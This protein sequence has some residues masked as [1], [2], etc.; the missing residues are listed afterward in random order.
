MLRAALNAT[1]QLLTILTRAT[2]PIA[3]RI[4]SAAA[5]PAAQPPDRNLYRP[6][7][8]RDGRPAPGRGAEAEA[9]R[10]LRQRRRAGRNEPGRR[11]IG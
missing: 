11:A 3:I 5:D 8:E 1:D 9:M 4:G 10:R 7:R 2:S 6:L